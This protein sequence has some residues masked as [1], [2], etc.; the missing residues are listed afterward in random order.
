L[1]DGSSNGSSSI[2]KPVGSGVS[3]R[4]SPIG[5]QSA[6]YSTEGS[7]F[8]AALAAQGAGVNNSTWIQNS[9]QDVIYEKLPADIAERHV[10]LM[11]PVLSTGNSAYTAIE[12]RTRGRRQGR[13][14]RLQ[15]PPARREQ[16][17][18]TG[19]R[20]ATPSPRLM[21]LLP[22]P[23]SDVRLCVWHRWKSSSH[24]ACRA[25][26]RYV[27]DRPVVC[28]LARAGGCRCCWRGV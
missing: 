14:Q 28:L 16:K 2:P 4:G 24:T 15:G 11:D 3:T 23:F 27:A 18:R 17:H 12:V 9:T 26:R 13:G 21:F 10:L 5:L 22:A 25:C 20:S 6:G 8:A 7:A 19:T 1:Q